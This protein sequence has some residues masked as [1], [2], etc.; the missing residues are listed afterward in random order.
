MGAM[1]HYTT[2]VIDLIELKRFQPGIIK[3]SVKEKEIGRNAL[4]FILNWSIVFTYS[5]LI[6]VNDVA[7]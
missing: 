6:Y 5:C 3:M 4:N 1:L 7:N 2:N